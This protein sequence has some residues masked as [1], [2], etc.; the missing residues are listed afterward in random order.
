MGNVREIQQIS[1]SA[2]LG[3]A[4][5]IR[6]GF[7]DTVAKMVGQHKQGHFY[8]YIAPA[9]V[10]YSIPNMYD[11]ATRI[12]RSRSPRFIIKSGGKMWCGYENFCDHLAAVAP[13]L[14]DA[15]FY[16]GDDYGDIDEFSIRNRQ[17]NRVRVQSG[18]W[19]TVED[20]LRERFPEVCE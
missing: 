9:D 14:E 6:E 20:Y 8:T 1:L 7:A 19:R 2:H 12:G 18:G 17:L 15:L 5:P 4:I 11:N 16:V 13:Y 3:V 10:E